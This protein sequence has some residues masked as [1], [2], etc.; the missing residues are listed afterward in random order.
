MLRYGLGEENAAKRIEDAVSE[1]LSKGFRT[2]DIFSS[3]MVITQR[4]RR[5]KYH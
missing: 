2:G 3:G 1:T 5:R 4:K